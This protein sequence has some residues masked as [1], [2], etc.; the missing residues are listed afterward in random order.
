MLIKNFVDREPC[1]HKLVYGINN[2][3]VING[4][5]LYCHETSLFDSDNYLQGSGIIHG[6][7]SYYL[8]PA[9]RRQEA[10]TK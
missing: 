9:L 3:R 1:E 4:R 5:C 10:K 6:H 2:N 7:Q 8:K